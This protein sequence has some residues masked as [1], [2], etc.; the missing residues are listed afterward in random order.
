MKRRPMAL[1]L[2][3]SSTP[4]DG[5]VEDVQK[6]GSGTQYIKITDSG[7][8]NTLHESLQI[9]AHGITKTSSPEHILNVQES[10]LEVVKP[11]GAGAFG[12]VNLVKVK[13]TGQLCAMKEIRISDEEQTQK[14]IYREIK[15]SISLSCNPYMVKTYNIYSHPGSILHILLEFCKYGSSQDMLKKLKTGKLTE[16]A[17]AVFI[18]D[19]LRGLAYLHDNCKIIHRD[20]KSANILIDEHGYC[21]LADF[22]VASSVL[23]NDDEAAMKTFVGSLSYMS[24]ERIQNQPYSY[25]SDVWSMGLTYVELLT[26]SYPYDNVNSFWDAMNVIVNGDPP[27]LKEDA[28]YSPGLCDLINAMLEKDPSKRMTAAQLLKLPF[29]KKY[30]AKEEDLRKL[31]VKWVQDNLK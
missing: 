9:S 3:A 26:G 21:K 31:F 7:S 19:T 5:S 8:L 6:G 16:N 24:P 13:T 23:P 12:T 28:G 2:D 25:V 11:L 30:L 14:N 22:G 10:D 27:L 18:I 4:T 1:T 15:A 20:I 17:L 29:C